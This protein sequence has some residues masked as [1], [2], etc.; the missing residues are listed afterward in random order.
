MYSRQFFLD[1]GTCHGKLASVNEAY[2]KGASTGPF[3]ACSANNKGCEEEAILT[4]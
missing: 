3:A 4:K 1:K 2:F